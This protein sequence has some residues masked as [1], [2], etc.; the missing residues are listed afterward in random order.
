[1][2]ETGAAIV[3]PDYSLAPTKQYPFQI[4][5][6]YAAL[7]YIV[8]EGQNHNLLTDRVVLAGD[9]VGGKHLTMR[10]SRSDLLH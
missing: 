1:M 8:R 2:R 10:A 4:N 3:F 5:Q 9:S 6:V 7:D